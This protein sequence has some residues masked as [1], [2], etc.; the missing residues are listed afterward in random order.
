MKPYKISV[1]R[2]SLILIG[3]LIYNFVYSIIYDSAGFAFII[4]WPAF[5]FSLA[6]ILLGNIIIFRDISKLKASLE[7]NELIQKTSTVQLVLATIGFFMQII[8]FKGAPLNYIDNYPLLVC[9]SIVYSI[10]IMIAIYQTI[11]LGQEKDNATIAG[12]IFGGMIIFLTIIALVIITSP[13]IK[14]TTKHTTPSFAEEFQSLGL[15]GKVEVVDKHREI[16][17]FY[18]TAYKLTYTENLSDGTI[19]KETTTAKIQGRSGE[20]LSNF[21]LLSGTD[22]ETLLNDKEKALFHTV[23]QD[24]FSFLLDV[25]KERPNF[26]QE[27]DSIKNAT[28]EKIDKLFA[29]PITSS[30]KFGKYP[31]ENYYVAIMAQAVSNREKGDSDAAGFYNI[32]TK[33]LMKNKGLTLDFDCDL[34]NIKAENASPVNAFKERV[35]SLPKNSFSDGIYNINCYYENRIQK[36]VEV[37]CPFVVED[38]VGHFEK[39]VIEGNQTN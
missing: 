22:L 30:F 25:Y 35:L 14:H 11:K 10:I 7:D 36:K 29:T 1:A 32:T 2:L 24:E 26:Q 12:F 38:G 5:F 17:A 8:G 18:G 20:H 15:K 33:D 23:K 9:A 16:E 37:T 31:I 13:S 4:L 34:S 28:A 3:Y 19:L 39:D 6:L 27:E 21:F